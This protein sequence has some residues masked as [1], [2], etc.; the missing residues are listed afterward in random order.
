MNSS[1]VK[2][3]MNAITLLESDNNLG[4]DMSGFTLSSAIVQSTKDSSKKIDVTKTMQN[5]IDAN[6]KL[7]IEPRKMNNYAGNDVHY[8]TLKQ[9]TL[10]FATVD[11]ITNV[12]TVSEN[13]RWVESKKYIYYGDIQ[14]WMVDSGNIPASWNPYDYQVVQPETG[15]ETSETEVPAEEN[16]AVEIKDTEDFKNKVQTAKD[17]VPEILLN[18][19]DNDKQVI[20]SLASSVFK[21]IIDNTNDFIINTTLSD[22]Q[23][24]T[25]LVGPDGTQSNLSKLS[26]MSSSFN[27]KDEHVNV[28]NELATGVFRNIATNI[29]FT[30]KLTPTGIQSKLTPPSDYKKMDLSI[31]DKENIFNINKDDVSA[32][33]VLAANVLGNII[34]EIF[35]Y[36]MKL[37]SKLTPEGTESTV[38]MTPP[39][40]LPML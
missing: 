22:G 26:D 33:N 37:N 31:F 19:S 29:K 28:I 4:F 32:I 15:T 12:K 14:S 3:T 30:S 36:G 2:P 24:T 20:Y 34:K 39:P 17:L 11:S 23:F 21:T 13:K 9:M 6:N 8:N 25:S 35:T 27:I 5:L 18:L 1:L 7:P 40:P 10:T 38:G 16:P